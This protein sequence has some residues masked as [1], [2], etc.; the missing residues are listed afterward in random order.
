M[1]RVLSADE[2]RKHKEMIESPDDWPRWPML[3]MKRPNPDMTGQMQVGIITATEGKM[4]T[5]YL[6]DMFSAHKLNDVPD[7]DRPKLV[8]Q[9]TAAILDDGWVVD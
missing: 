2:F 1:P 3:P 5:V 8:Y 9:D 7:E 6:T 4:T